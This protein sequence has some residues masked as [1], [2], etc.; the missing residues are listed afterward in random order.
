MVC[1]VLLAESDDGLVLVDTGFGTHDCTHPARLGGVRRHVIRPA[2]DP[3]ETALAQVIRL[4]FRREDVRHIIVTHFDADHI[5]GLA[6]FPDAAVHVSST[7]AVGSVFSR[8]PFGHRRFRSAQWSHGPRI[9]E[10]GWDGEP[11]QGFA[12]A[13]PIP[14]L[15]PGF[16]LVS[17]PG[18]T[19]GHLGVA[20][21][22]GDRWILHAGDAFYHSRALTQP[23]R[24]PG[25]MRALERAAATDAGKVDD[26]HARLAEL[27]R[28]GDPA[29]T[30]VCSH[31]AALFD[32]ARATARV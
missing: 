27:V 10:H 24:V 20:V 2:L 29:L 15:G 3:G 30:V 4:G 23:A 8:A 21:D 11:W 31:D 9:V 14:A 7:E 19:A 28:R 16:V 32:R 12:A 25:W 18:H 1:H 13:R 17:L 6:D 22:A 26:N 5:G